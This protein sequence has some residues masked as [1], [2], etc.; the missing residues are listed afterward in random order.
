MQA[1]NFKIIPGDD[2][3]WNYDE[4]LEFLIAYQ[5]K[6]IQISINSEGA[7]LTSIGVYKLLDLFKFNSVTIQTANTVEYHPTY[8]IIS[9]PN[10][11]FFLGATDIY[12]QYHTWNLSKVFGAMYN[13]P[14]W[15]RIG[16]A[17]NLAKLST[18]L[19]F[20]ADPHNSDRK[21]FELQKLFNIHSESV[22]KFVEC[23]S[24]FP[25]QLSEIDTYTTGGT[26]VQHTDQLC[27]FYENFLIDVVAETFVSGRTFF[28]TEKTVR[29]ILLKK[30][31]IIMGPKCFLIH[32]RQMGFKTFGEFWD[33]S[34]D[35][36]EP[37]TRYKMILDL[38]DNLS[39][40]SIKELQDMYIQMQP[41]LDHN[42]NLLIEKNYN[43]QIGY[44][45]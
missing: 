13:R 43:F 25:V 21:F 12:K 5:H 17:S 9:M 36:Y 15:H 28:P 45:E 3:I 34:Y 20:R 14:S 19:N 16:L 42:Y 33:E 18:T 7:C 10:L 30:P 4:F 32:L 37:A 6:D 26:L 1:N 44:V 24:S 23:K 8:T 22:N 39:K 11:R 31:F 40:K 41:I 27:G 29:P 35:G 38:I 2:F